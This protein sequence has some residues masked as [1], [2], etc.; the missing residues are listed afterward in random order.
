MRIPNKLIKTGYFWLPATAEARLPGTLKISESG[1]AELEIIGVF[2]GTTGMFKNDTNIGRINGVVDGEGPVTL[3]GCFYRNRHFSSYGISRSAIHIDRVFIGVHYDDR[4][5]IKFSSFKFSLEGF[6]E[7]LSVS[8]IKTKYG[9]KF[10]SASIKFSSPKEIRIKLTCDVDLLFTFEWTIPVGGDIA[11]AKI[12]QKS[13]VK[14]KSR[15]LLALDDFILLAFRLNN[16]FCFAMDETVTFTSIIGTS[17]K[18]KRKI[19]NK[20]FEIPIKIFYPSLPFSKTLPDVGLHEMLFRYGQVA[21]NLEKILD[22]WMQA[23]ERIEPALNLY[24]ASKSGA[25][26]Y[27]EGRFLSLAQGIETFHRRTSKETTMPENEFKSV[28]ATLLGV[29]PQTRKEW[30][31]SLLGYAN[32]VSLRKRLKRMM[33]PFKPYYG[34]ARE[35]ESLIG[36]IVNTRNYLVHYDKNL[37]KKALSGGEL[38]G[39]CMKIEGLFQLHLL[40]AIGFTGDVIEGIVKSNGQ[41]ARKLSTSRMGLSQQN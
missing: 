34:A 18:L 10:R 12:T 14:L 24:F 30:L 28:V 21:D 31:E 37:E 5:E 32:E 41:L 22:K 29:C 20:Q 35:R 25:H 17:Y 8:G 1:E 26:K 16:F 39:I 6:D 7:W 27:L 11:E 3:D 40:R 13:L 23:Y 15:K 4:E 9:R 36:N 19:Q 33:D 2:G 38:W